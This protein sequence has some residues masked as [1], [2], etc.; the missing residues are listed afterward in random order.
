MIFFSALT[1]SACKIVLEVGPIL[2]SIKL[3]EKYH[4]FL[5]PKVEIPTTQEILLFRLIICAIVLFFLVLH[6]L[7]H[8]IAVFTE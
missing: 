1:V 2:S 5:K 7:L 3:K 6:M 4:Y 8:C